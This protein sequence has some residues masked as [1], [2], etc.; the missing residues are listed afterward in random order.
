MLVLDKLSYG[1]ELK[2]N[3]KQKFPTKTRRSHYGVDDDV[4]YWNTDIRYVDDK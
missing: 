1:E 2:I 3:E 4:N